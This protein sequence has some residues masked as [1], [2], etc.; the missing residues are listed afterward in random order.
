M[1]QAQP[2]L[3]RL[4]A[5][6]SGRSKT[7]N[8]GTFAIPRPSTIRATASNARKRLLTFEVRSLSRLPGN[9]GIYELGRAGRDSYCSLVKQV[10]NMQA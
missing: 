2:Q 7:D 10:P 5:I 8:S 1:R 4:R 9:G 3:A 6:S